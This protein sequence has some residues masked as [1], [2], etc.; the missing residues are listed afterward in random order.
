MNLDRITP[1]LLTWNESINIRH[2]LEKLHWAKDIVVVDSFSDDGTV[3]I[4]KTFPN[5]RVIQRKF[6]S[7]ANQWNYAIR[8]TGI[9]TE[10]IL[11]LDAD[12]V[13]SD[14]LIN[15]L[16]N[17]EEE[18]NLAAYEARFIYCVWGK[19][20]RNTIYPPAQVLYRKSLAHYIQDGH[21]QR[22]KAEGP[23]GK[24]KAQIFH[25]DRKPFKVWFQAQTR[26]AKLEAQKLGNTRVRQ[27]NWPDRIRKLY[28]VA[29]TAIF[30][31]CL[32]GKG[33]V[34][35]GLNGIYYAFQRFIA[36]CLLSINLFKQTKN[37]FK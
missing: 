11:A 26:Y 32:L 2:T 10:W 28:F 3:S 18:S 34:L 22:L 14:E 20:L 35:H 25:D 9:Q 31:Y 13:L 23:V 15:E 6:D 24:L 7:H 17:L 4:L 29:P 1:V 30:F 8:E 33:L 21:T 12:Y 19:P 16:K 5:V 27:L 36:E 37:I